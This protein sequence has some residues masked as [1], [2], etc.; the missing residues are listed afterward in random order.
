MLVSII[1]PLYNGDKY[2]AKNIESI[3]GQSFK[4]FEHIIVNDGST[5]KSAEIVRSFGNKIVYLEQKNAGQ[6]AAVNAGIKIAKGKYVGFCDQD[7]WWL[8][9]KLKIQ[10]DFLKSHPGVSL[11]YSDAL[12]ADAEG[13]IVNQTWMQSRG[14]GPCVGGYKDCIV[15]LLNRNFICAPLTVLMRKEVFDKVGLLD[16]E[17]SVIYD[18]DFWFRMLERGMKFGYINKPLGVYRIHVNQESKKI[19]K[20]KMVQIK[21]LSSFLRRRKSFLLRHPILIIK[22]YIRSYIGLIFNRV[23]G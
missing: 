9:E 16:D 12:L 14:V 11:V 23:G 4:D 7:D 13:K 17:F 2:I 5:D 1:T 22:K 8:P 10:V 19:R 20:V 3:L 15:S 21:I 18:Y 6:A